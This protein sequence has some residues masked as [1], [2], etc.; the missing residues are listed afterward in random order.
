MYYIPPRLPET[1]F[2]TSTRAT[3][4]R[5]TS[6]HRWPSLPCSKPL[7]TLRIATLSASVT[8]QKP[9]CHCAEPDLSHI[10]LRKTP[11]SREKAWFT[12]I[13]SFLRRLYGWF[14]E[15]H[16]KNPN[17][18][19]VFIRPCINN[20]QCFQ[21]VYGSKIKITQ[22]LRSALRAYGSTPPRGW[23]SPIIFLILISILIV[24]SFDRSQSPEH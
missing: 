14:F 2:L 5:E 7:V 18:F 3:E 1:S 21:E 15:S 13:L 16:L 8:P 12:A 11:L 22:C 6:A 10:T 9:C 19:D 20:R 23:V 4:Q 17:V 24:Q